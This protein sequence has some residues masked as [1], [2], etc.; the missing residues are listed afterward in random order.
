[1]NAK[2]S[3]PWVFVDG[4]FVPLEAA[5]ISVHA[6]AVSYGT[7]VFEGI[8]ACSN[9]AHGELYLLQPREHYDRMHLSARAL[10]LVLPLST[11]ELVAATIELLRR[12]DLRGDAYV[13]PLFL[14]SGEVLTVR[15]DHVETRLSIAAWSFEDA[16]VDPGGV[17]CMVSSWRRTP[18]STLP[19][20]A[21][22][23]GSYVGPALAKTE[24]LSAGFQ[25]AIMLTVDGSVAEASTSNVFIRR[26][27]TWST[28]AVTE[29][30]LEGI[31]RQEVMEL[32]REDLDEP[33][34]E[35]PVD[36]SELYV[37]DEMLIC[38]T[39]VEVVP[40]LGV[41]RRPVGSG[42]A[43]ERTLRLRRSLRGIA[44][45][46]DARHPEWTTPVYARSEVAA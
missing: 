37:C 9:E 10:G 42:L 46:Q 22:V 32:I 45:R 27:G 21:K 33:V 39:A 29:D 23:I 30:I 43:G 20:R 28:P 26:G 14:L 1:M 3:L 13:R 15:I 40:V 44:R 11:D 24:A 16:Y 18:D 12:N 38:G 8:R 31:T 34:V 19:I 6:Q 7:G 25:E 17:Q 4:E 41:D 35:R 5:R 2:N 36:R